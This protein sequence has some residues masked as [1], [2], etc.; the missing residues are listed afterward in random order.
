MRAALGA[1]RTRLVRQMLTESTL[2]GV[3]GGA[4]GIL[5]AMWATAAIVALSPAQGVALPGSAA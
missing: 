4:V 2:L 3:L 1:N 5:L